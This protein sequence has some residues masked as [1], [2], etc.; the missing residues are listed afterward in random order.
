M[1]AVKS[2]DHPVLAVKDL[3]KAAAC[4]QSLGFFLSP[5]AFHGDHMGTSNH[6]V[7]FAQHNFIELLEVDRPD[8]IT[9][10]DH[11]AD[12]PSFSFGAGQRDFLAKGSG[13]SMLAFD[14]DDALGDLERFKA[15][16]LKTYTPFHFRRQTTLP[17]GSKTP[18][19]FTLGFVT[20]PKLPNLAFFFCQE[21]APEHFW[22][23]DYQ[24]HENG[25]QGIR[26]L[27]LAADD[28]AEH[29]AFFQTLTGGDTTEIEGGIRVSLGDQGIFVLTPRRL[30]SIAPSYR[31]DS[32][33]PR[34][35]GLGIECAGTRPTDVLPDDMGGLFIK[36]NG[37]P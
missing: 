1:T 16:G 28:P 23:P 30:A 8:G 24:N 22:K 33:P 25:A 36:W 27:Y 21:D 3:D 12:P 29:G 35:A 37:A 32:G 19:S 17:D 4:F 31:P 6:V 26:S 7:Q 18:V 11:S 2:I 14:T 13:I 5:R 20:N 10:H 34:F 15:A 9:P